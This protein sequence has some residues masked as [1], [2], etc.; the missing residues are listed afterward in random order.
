MWPFFTQYSVSAGPNNR[1]LIYSK[2][3]DGDNSNQNVVSASF[4]FLHFRPKFLE[5]PYFSNQ[6]SFPFGVGSKTRDSIVV[7][8]RFTTR[9]SRFAL[10]Q[11]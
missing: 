7:R 3:P 1:L 9:L 5:L 10:E 8:T 6:S 4:V 2:T 11:Q